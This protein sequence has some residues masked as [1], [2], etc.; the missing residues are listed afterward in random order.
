MGFCIGFKIEKAFI[1]TLKQLLINAI[2]NIL[3]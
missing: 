3:L 2:L 1:Y